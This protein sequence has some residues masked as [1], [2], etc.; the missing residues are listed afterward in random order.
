M[1]RGHF[2]VHQ[3]WKRNL[4]ADCKSGRLSMGSLQAAVEN[5]HVLVEE[6]WSVSPRIVDDDE[7]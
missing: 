6:L 3:W 5:F 2:Q 1:A 4:L 7:G